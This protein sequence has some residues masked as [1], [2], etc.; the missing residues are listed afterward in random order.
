MNFSMSRGFR[1]TSFPVVALP[2]VS[3]MLTLGPVISFKSMCLIKCF[4][5]DQSFGVIVRIS[6]SIVR[7]NPMYPLIGTTPLV[8][9]RFNE[10]ARRMDDA[11][12]EWNPCKGNVIAARREP[13]SRNES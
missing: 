7:R 13:A 3:V 5:E 10:L 1:S 2:A 8:G 9:H 11:A 4:A 6:T 12:L